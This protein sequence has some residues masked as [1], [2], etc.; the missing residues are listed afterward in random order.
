MFSGGRTLMDCN[1]CE[2]FDDVEK[3]ARVVSFSTNPAGKGRWTRYRQSH[4]G[5]LEASG[6]I[7]YRIA[8][9]AGGIAL[10]GGRH[11]GSRGGVQR[12]TP[13]L[14]HQTSSG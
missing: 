1:A 13:L 11:L 14:F 4:A 10:A 8:S 12:G 3:G 2:W 5:A 6:A 9:I 7:A